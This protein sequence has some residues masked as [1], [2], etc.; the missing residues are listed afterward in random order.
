AGHEKP[1]ILGLGQAQGIVCAQGADL[2]GLDGELQ[3][4]HGAGWR[5]KV[6]DMVDG[7]VD[8][9]RVGDIVPDEAEAIVVSQVLDV[10]QRP[11][12]DV[13]YADDFVP[14][15]QKTLT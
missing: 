14:A 13:V 12:D 10:P 9:Q 5:G 1:G 11:G 7:S 2:Q 4:I 3:V 6:Q 15:L 8:L